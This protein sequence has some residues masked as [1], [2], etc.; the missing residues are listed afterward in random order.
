MFIECQWSDSSLVSLLTD[1]R[2]GTCAGR[3]LLLSFFF[4]FNQELGCCTLTLLI[5][6]LKYILTSILIG[7]YI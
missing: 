5:L 1:V 2:A 7:L 6:K 4:F 3:D